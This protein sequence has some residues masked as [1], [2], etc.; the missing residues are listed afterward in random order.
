[1]GDECGV[2]AILTAEKHRRIAE[3]TLK[4]RQHIVVGVE[5]SADIRISINGAVDK[6]ARQAVRLLE[7]RRTR[8]AAPSPPP[9]SF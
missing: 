4:F 6:L 9:R 1:M 5:E 8:S 7:R 2:H 3:F